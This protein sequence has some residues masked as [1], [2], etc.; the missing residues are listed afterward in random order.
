MVEAFRGE[1]R[2]WDPNVLERFQILNKSLVWELRVRVDVQ[3]RGQMLGLLPMQLNICAQK[4]E[5]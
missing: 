5:K 2:N 4:V 3:T 1:I